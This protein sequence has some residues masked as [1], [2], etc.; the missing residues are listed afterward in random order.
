MG[1]GGQRQLQ[2]QHT[3]TAPQIGGPD[4]KPASDDV[5]E[6]WK[7]QYPLPDEDSVG[8]FN[9]VKQ[10]YRLVAVAVDRILTDA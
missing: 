4:S 2:P 8:S 9:E 7:A 5:V 10:L 3:I 1:R 6:L